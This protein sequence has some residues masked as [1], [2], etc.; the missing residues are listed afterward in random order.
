MKSTY[1]RYWNRLPPT[2]Q[3]HSPPSGLSRLYL[4]WRHRLSSAQVL[5]IMIMR[6]CSQTF[7]LRHRERCSD[8]IEETPAPSASWM[9]WLRMGRLSI[10]VMSRSRIANTLSALNSWPALSGTEKT[11]L[12]LKTE[13]PNR[14]A[15]HRTIQ[16]CHSV[17]SRD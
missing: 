15:R 1:R 16:P 3:L 2:A 9:G 10:F 11:T 7:W 13:A 5:N 12:V 4:L 17:S 14:A 8:M 6:D